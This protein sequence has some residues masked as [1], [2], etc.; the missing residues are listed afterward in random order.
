ML[1]TVVAEQPMFDFRIFPALDRLFKGLTKVFA[2]PVR[3][4]F[5]KQETDMPDGPVAVVYAVQP[6]D[7]AKR[8]VYIYWDGG[9]LDMKLAHFVERNSSGE[10]SRV[11]PDKEER[12]PDDWRKAIAAFAAKE[13]GFV[14]PKKTLG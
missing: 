2:Q 5:I 8:E 10:F 4:E 1:D 3:V 13:Q 14:A 12:V 6:V 7:G 9:S 11:V